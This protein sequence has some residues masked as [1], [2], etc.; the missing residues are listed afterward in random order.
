MGARNLSNRRLG[1]LSCHE[2]ASHVISKL[3][4]CPCRVTQVTQDDRLH[5]G[6]DGA[7]VKPEVSRRRKWRTS[8]LPAL[9][10][11]EER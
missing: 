6:V 1:V 5:G 3:L 4:H 2:K 8:R 9:L 11:V 7:E 10:R